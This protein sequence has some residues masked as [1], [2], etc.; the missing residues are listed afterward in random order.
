MRDTAKTRIVCN[1]VVSKITS[2]SVRRT[3]LVFT[4]QFA[5]VLSAQGPYQQ[6][7][8][9][10]AQGTWPHSCAGRPPFSLVQLPSR[11]GDR[12]RAW[13]YDVC[14]GSA[15]SGNRDLPISRWNDVDRDES[16]TGS[17][18]TPL[19]CIT[20][21]LVGRYILLCGWGTGCCLFSSPQRKHVSK[22]RR[23]WLLGS[24]FPHVPFPSRTMLCNHPHTRYS[25]VR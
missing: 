7:G 13:H 19:E 12:D 9:S 22:R 5:V 11:S 15:C 17:L 2:T 8:I 18:P 3:D 16:P 14:G 10:L 4:G 20:R 6:Y 25:L 21:G 24:V 1:T 23:T